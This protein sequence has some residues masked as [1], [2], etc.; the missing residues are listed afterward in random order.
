MYIGNH[1]IKIMDEFQSELRSFAASKRGKSQKLEALSAIL[2]NQSLLKEGTIIPPT[3]SLKDRSDGVM[4]PGTVGEWLIRVA[5]GPRRRVALYD[6]EN[7]AALERLAEAVRMAIAEE[8]SVEAMQRQ[9]E[10][11]IAKAHN[12]VYN[13]GKIIAS[14]HKHLQERGAGYELGVD[15]SK[16]GS[17]EEALKMANLTVRYGSHVHA[18]TKLYAA[19]MAVLDQLKR[20]HAKLA[21]ETA[22]LH[23]ISKE[24]GDGISGGVAAMGMQRLMRQ[25]RVHG[26]ILSGAAQL[27]EDADEAAAQ[28][29]GAAPPIKRD[30][31]DA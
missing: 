6:P 22:E 15:F 13:L 30:P 1:C 20:E 27:S 18:T 8:P 14:A 16:Y 5:P 24:E 4:G 31:R 3:K 2:C 19:F 7:P 23:A 10:Q 21:K 25:A 9:R 17:P 11:V 28:M 29:S 12:S 26:D